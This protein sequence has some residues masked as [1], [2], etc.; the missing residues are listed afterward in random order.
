MTWLA[1]EAVSK[2]APK[3]GTLTASTLTAALNTAKNVN[4][5][6]VIPPWTPSKQ[7]AAPFTRINNP[8][9]Y[10]EN[11]KDGQLVLAQSA[12]LNVRASLG[13]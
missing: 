1:V 13:I 11:I 3:S 5:M 2:V 10:I 7:G 9:V 8:N 12:E 4:L 6:G